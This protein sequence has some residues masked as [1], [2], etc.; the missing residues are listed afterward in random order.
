M[1]EQQLPDPPTK[2]QARRVRRMTGRDQHEPY[3][4]A[5]PLELLF[6][7]TFVAAFGGCTS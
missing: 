4:T 7:L 6:D 1:S 2:V 5:T 3:R